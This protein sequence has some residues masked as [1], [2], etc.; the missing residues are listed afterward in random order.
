MKTIIALLITC[1]LGFIQPGYA[2]HTGKIDVRITDKDK[3]PMNGTLVELVNANNLELVKFVITN[4]DG[5]AE[6]SILNEGKYLVFVP[7][8]GANNY[9]SSV[10]DINKAQKYLALGTIMLDSRTEGEIVVLGKAPVWTAKVV[11]R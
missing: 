9:I 1:S 7:Q 10:V 8:I 6:F 5:Y 3:K 2:Q 11:S 4:E